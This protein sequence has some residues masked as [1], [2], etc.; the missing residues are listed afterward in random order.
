MGWH[1]ASLIAAYKERVK[2]MALGFTQTG[3]GG[4]FTAILKYDGRAGKIFRE[5]R[6]QD[7]TGA[8]V[9]S[10]NE[11]SRN[12]KAVFDFENIEVGYINFPAGGAPDFQMVALGDPFP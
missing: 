8:W 9:K 1:A 4:D 12:F 6:A 5:D 10:S 2:D 11:I 7:A 3:G